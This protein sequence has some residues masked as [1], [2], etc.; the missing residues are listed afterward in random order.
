MSFVFYDT[1]TTGTSTHFDQILQFAAILTDDEL[2]VVDQ[3]E[4][5]CRLL[6]HVVPGPKAMQV[7]GVTVKQLTDPS[8]CSHYQMVRTIR[9]KLISWTPAT[10]VGWN[11]IDFDEELM[12]QAFFKTLH[13]PYLT[14]QQGNSR[15]DL[16]KTVQACSLAAKDILTFPLNEKGNITFKLDRLAPANGFN[17]DKAHDALADVEATIFL[18]RLV[19]TRAPELWTKFLRFSTKSGVTDYIT[20]EPVFCVS[21]FAF[22]KP[23]ST[24]VTT[25]GQNQINKAEWYAYDLSFDP[26]LVTCYSDAQLLTA[27]VGSP[28]LVRK[29]KSNAAPILSSCE[30]APY[31]CRG[32]ELSS[33]TIRERVDFIRSSTAF[34]ERI[35]KILESSKTEYPA[36]PHVEKQIYSGFFQNLDEKLMEK[37]H[38]VAWPE[39]IA[40]VEQMQDPRLKLLANHLIHLEFPD[41]LDQEASLRHHSNSA[42]RLMG[43]VEDVDWLTLPKA[44]EAVVLLLAD[45]T[46]EE[47]PLLQEH[48]QFLRKLEEDARQHL[49]AET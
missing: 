48:E 42:K 23:L 36:S 6:P 10:F 39:R 7:T 40:I 3:F 46:D 4:I 15:A 17:H 27:L 16:M 30:D 34:R 31:A 37:F 22:G 29:V 44:I 47:R 25:I 5:R 28:K 35:I 14:Q 45:S 38:S 2:N 21:E 1:E 18:A 12:R 32:K 41:L 8:Y 20:K 24:F 19:K 26:H 13:N 9:E 33:Q 43:E 49:R 11:S